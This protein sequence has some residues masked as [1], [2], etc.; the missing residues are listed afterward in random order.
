MVPEGWL[1][2]LVLLSLLF[3]MVAGE[4]L[5][6]DLI[7]QPLDG[8]HVLSLYH[9]EMVFKT[10]NGEEF[11]TFP[12]PLGQAL[13]RYQPRSLEFA[14]TQGRWYAYNGVHS[15]STHSLQLEGRLSSPMY[16]PN[17]CL[18]EVTSKRILMRIRSQ[19]S[20]KMNILATG[21]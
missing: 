4:M 3:V 8:D 11:G 16:G 12:K 21:Y 6:E 10:T 17:Q 14:L 7:I 20:M 1:R 15:I 19:Q 9:Y 5:R 18:L 2:A 13:Y